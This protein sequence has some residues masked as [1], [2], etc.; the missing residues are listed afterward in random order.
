MIIEVITAKKY[1]DDSELMI[2]SCDACGKAIQHEDKLVSLCIF[3]DD[4]NNYSCICKN[5]INKLHEDINK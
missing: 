5:C 2:I 3:N 4:Y 1:Q